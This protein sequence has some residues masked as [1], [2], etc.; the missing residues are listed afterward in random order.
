MLAGKTNTNSFQTLGTQYLENLYLL[1][2]SA[3][4]NNI[5]AVGIPD[6]PIECPA[7]GP[8]ARLFL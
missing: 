7:F 5:I 3:N 2:N 6:H 8:E 1:C 4:I